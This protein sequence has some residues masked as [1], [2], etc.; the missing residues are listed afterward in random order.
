M[1]KQLSRLIILIAIL[2]VLMGFSGYV[3]FMSQ[4]SPYQRI[5][6]ELRNTLKN[7]SHSN[8]KM[9]QDKK[10]GFEFQYPT[11]WIKQNLPN[12]N[13]VSFYPPIINVSNKQDEES[14][15]ATLTYYENSN[16][17]EVAKRLFPGLQ[18]YSSIQ[19]AVNK[20]ADILDYKE[21]I[22]N[23]HNISYIFS[24]GE[25]GWYNYFIPLKN[26]IVVL[27]FDYKTNLENPNLLSTIRIY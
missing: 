23:G 26:G 1:K 11:T 16:A 24:G 3:L 19:E 6:G 20:E 9:Y 27:S 5:S 25:R 12:S 15:I 8:W 7:T 4:S 21:E 10:Y 22:I 2:I 14:P 13:N 18:K 17:N